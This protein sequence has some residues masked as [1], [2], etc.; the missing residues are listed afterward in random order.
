MQFDIVRAWKDEAYYQSL[1]EEQLSALPIN[2]AGEL[3]DADLA[4][5]SGAGGFPGSDVGGVGGVGVGAVGVGVGVQH[6]R[7]ESVALIC[8][9]NVF[10]VS[11]ISNIAILGS[12]TQFCAKG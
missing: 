3:T 1:S 5:I 6:I 8:E 7:N 4:G 9:I 10:S 2:P 12:V 11:I